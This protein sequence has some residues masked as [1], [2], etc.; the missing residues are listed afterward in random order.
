M[1]SFDPDRELEP[2]GAYLLE[3]KAWRAVSH[4]AQAG[5]WDFILRP[6]P[7]WGLCWGRW[8]T[9]LQPLQLPVRTEACVLCVGP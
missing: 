1:G 3:M 9:H 5:V 2:L 4:L 7:S 6:L 8:P